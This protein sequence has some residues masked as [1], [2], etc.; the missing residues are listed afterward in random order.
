MNIN[1]NDVVSLISAVSWPITTVWCAYIFRSEI[2]GLATR[3]SHL[4]YKDVEATFENELSNTEAKVNAITNNQPTA[5]PDSELQSKVDQLQRISNVSPRAA[6]LESWLLIENAAGQSGFVQGADV[7]RINSLLFVDWLVREG[8]LPHDSIDVV[9][10]L[11]EMRN[12]AAHLPDF[13]INQDDAER[14]I[15]LAAK[16]S[17]LIIEPEKSSQD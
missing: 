2:R 4:K 7:P 6:I 12:K 15:R 1:M 5:F 17:T 9:S 14:Y 8:K 16:I 10:S 13:L 3:V 11:R